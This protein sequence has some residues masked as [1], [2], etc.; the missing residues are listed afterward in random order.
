MK[1]L[2]ERFGRPLRLALIGGGPTSWIG[3]MHQT[4]AEL[5]GHWR[6]VGGVFSSDPARSR[7]AG[8]ELSFDPSTPLADGLLAEFEW[9]R[10]EAISR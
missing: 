10:D 5:D 8:K 6:V 3:R 4:A 9:L 2:R 7:Q 1:G